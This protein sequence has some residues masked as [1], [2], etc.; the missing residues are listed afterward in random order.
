MHKCDS[1]GGCSGNCASCNGCAGSLLLTQME[2]DMLHTFAQL[3]FLP[4][5][6]KADDMTP[7]YLDGAGDSSLVLQCLEKKGLIDID[8]HQS[9]SG[10]DYG[11]YSA[12]P[13]RGS[14]ALTARGQE[15]LDT[16]EVQ[17]I[18]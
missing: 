11:D 10:F 16:L 2:I 7:I 15:V 3:P 1:C 14:M 18:Q 6:R 12:Y 4:V 13:V 17:G 5:A 9:L 8:Y